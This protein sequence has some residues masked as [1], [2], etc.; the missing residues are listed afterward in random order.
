[1]FATV[2]RHVHN[3]LV[4]MMTSDRANHQTCP[5]RVWGSFGFLTLIGFMGFALHKGGTFDPA[6]YG[7]AIS[8][9]LICWGGALYAKGKVSE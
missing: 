9:Y 3:I 4:Q 1:M 2:A 5:F 8:A 7:G 6:G